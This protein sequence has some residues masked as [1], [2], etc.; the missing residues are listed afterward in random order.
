M[1]DLYCIVFCYLLYCYIYFSVVL[2]FI[3]LL[4]IVLFIVLISPSEHMTS[5]DY[6][7]ITITMAWI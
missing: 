6:A 2:L 4:F 1:L 7:P 3:V 5:S